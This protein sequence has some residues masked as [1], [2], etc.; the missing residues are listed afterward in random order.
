MPID[1]QIIPELTDALGAGFEKIIYELNGSNNPVGGSSK[2]KSRKR[3]VKGGNIQDTVTVIEGGS[4]KSKSRKSRKVAS[5]KRK[6]VRKAKS[7]SRKAKSP[8]RKSHQIKV[9]PRTAMG[10]FLEKN[11][12]VVLGPYRTREEAVKAKL[13]LQGIMHML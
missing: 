5:P 11:K 10:Y 3:K 4:K 9:G 13:R 7:R 8:S 6:S 2:P 12:Q 1:V